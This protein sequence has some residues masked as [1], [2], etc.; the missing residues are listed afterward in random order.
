MNNSITSLA[1]SALSN[2]GIYALLLGSGISKTSGVPTGWD[3]VIDLIEKLAILEKE[4]CEPSPEVWF[5]S[6]FGEEPNY[7]NILAKLVKTPSERVNFLKPYFEGSENE[8]EQG[9]KQPTQAHQA[10]AKLAKK[11]IVKVV[12]T[13]NFDRLIEKSLQLEGIEPLVIRHGD[14]IDGALPL[15]HTNFTLI[16]INGDY[17]DSRFLNTREELSSYSRKLHNYILRVINEFGIISCGWSGKW[18]VG[19]LNILRQS[20]NFRFSSYWT[21][22]DTCEEELNEIAQY[23]KGVTLK[24]DNANSF[25]SELLDK[26]TALENYNVNH[27]LSSDIAIARLKKYIVKDE[28]KIL[29]H[30]LI[31][32]QLEDSFEKI[33]AKIDSGL[34]PNKENLYPFLGYFEKNLDIL[35][36]LIINGVFWSRQE[37]EYLF[38]NILSRF[39]ETPPSSTGTTYDVTRN[40]FYF[41]SL[42]ILYAIG[43]SAIKTRKFKL[44]KE[45]F[46]LKINEH[47]SEF[48]EQL[49]IIDRVNSCLFDKRAMNE[50]ISKNYKTPFSSFLKKTL[51]PYFKTLFVNDSEYDGCFDIFEYMLSL[52]YAYYIGE[53]YGR[54]WAPWG[55][56]Q[57]KRNGIRKRHSFLDDFLDEADKQK[58]HWAPLGSGMFDGEYERYLKTKEKLDEFLS[59]IHLD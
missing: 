25:F 13:T 49:I 44:L 17:L 15:V 19:L 42:L 54:F 39:S 8:L 37:H 40:F 29:L 41:P 18:D 10:I 21:F 27:P 22:I 47:D 12:I 51:E 58:S 43:V 35:I 23:R 6:K 45:S 3:I 4:T 36:A 33:N 52:N 56:F 20:E 59:E 53:K 34:Y 24:I 14:D 28:G 38:K 7:S 32:T 55:E 26:I 16:K 31:V 1:F 11:G 50:I 46:K 57:W 30:D 9:L 5:K 2:K 48:S